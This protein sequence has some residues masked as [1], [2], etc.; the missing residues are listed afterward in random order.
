MILAIASIKG[1]TGKTTLALALAA[2]AL[3]RGRR[4]LL[5]DGDP[6][7]Q[8]H[9]CSELHPGLHAI[10]LPPRFQPHQIH[11][12]AMGHDFTVIDTPPGDPARTQAV[13]EAADAVLVPCGPSPLDA[14]ALTPA[15]GCVAAARTAN[16]RLQS[17]VVVNRVDRRTHLGRTAADQ[18]RYHGLPVLDV[19]IAQRVVYAEVVGAGTSVSGED[20][21][22]DARAEIEALLDEV[23]DRLMAAPEHAAVH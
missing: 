14:W 5:V 8:A 19:E 1:G 16:P 10:G 23:R 4:V 11:M 3:A 15:L 21:D 9:A 13:L 17:A 12:L 20:V 7:L 18:L 22:P 6:A 2:E